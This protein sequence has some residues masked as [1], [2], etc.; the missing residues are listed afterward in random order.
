MSVI[1]IRGHLGSGAPEIGKMVADRLKADY[2]DREIIAQVAELIR[3]PHQG[4]AEKEKPPGTLGE[5]VREAL[6]HIRTNVAPYIPAREIP[7]DDATYLWGLESVI[8]EL[9]ARSSV[10]IRGRGS[11][12]ILKD[13]PGALHVLVVSPLD[14]RVKH[15]MQTQ[16]LDEEMVKKEIDRSDTSRREFTRRYF[17]AELED[18]LYYDLVINTRYLTF[19][20][21]ASVVLNTLPFKERTGLQGT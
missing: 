7:L 6:S 10:V 19:E 4:V 11:Q 14:L 3:W 8:K 16:K 12:F 9:A 21:A 2:V 1:T 13:Y 17:K 20:D 18:P 15:L 5:R